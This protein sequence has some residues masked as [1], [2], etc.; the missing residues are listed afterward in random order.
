MNAKR[1]QNKEAC[2]CLDFLAQHKEN[3]VGAMKMITREESE[4]YFRRCANVAPNTRRLAAGPDDDELILVKCHF[5]DFYKPKSELIKEFGFTEADIAFVDGMGKQ[6]QVRD[7]KQKSDH[8][9]AQSTNKKGPTTIEL[10][11]SYFRKCSESLQ[12]LQNVT[13]TNKLLGVC[14]D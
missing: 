3:N 13:T 4:S 2:L 14:V 5:F 11:N 6:R 7:G 1:R 8:R 10:I 9:V 12:S